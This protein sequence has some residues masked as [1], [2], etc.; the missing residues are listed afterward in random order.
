MCREEYTIPKGQDRKVPRFL[1]RMLGLPI[2]EQV[3]LLNLERL[4]GS[5]VTEAVHHIA[6]ERL[7][8]PGCLRVALPDVASVKE[9][10]LRALDF[11]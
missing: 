7:G 4:S 9:P 6:Y 1:N 2:D 10:L 5:L 11:S 8:T 3:G